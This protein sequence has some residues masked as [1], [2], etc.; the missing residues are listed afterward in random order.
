MGKKSTKLKVPLNLS[1]SYMQPVL[2]EI[3]SSV[4]SDLVVA[5][6]WIDISTGK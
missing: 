6:Q 3:I 5:K 1:F 4:R 2:D